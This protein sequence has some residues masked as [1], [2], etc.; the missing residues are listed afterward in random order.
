MLNTSSIFHAALFLPLWISSNLAMPRTQSQFYDFLFAYWVFSLVPIFAYSRR[1]G[2]TRHP[3]Q[4]HRS[5]FLCLQQQQLYNNKMYKFS[6]VSKLYS[7]ISLLTILSLLFAFIL[8]WNFLFKVNN[9]RTAATAAQLP[10]THRPHRGAAT[11]FPLAARPSPID[12]LLPINWLLP[13][14]SKQ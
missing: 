7:A 11:S 12:W 4:H 10:P 6:L 8:I 14:R 9:G 5:H 2:L 3:R 13:L 1:E